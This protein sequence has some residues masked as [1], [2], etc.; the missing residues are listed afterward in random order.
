MRRSGTQTWKKKRKGRDGKSN[1]GK[2]RGNTE[3]WEE[4]REAAEEDKGSEVRRGTDERAQPIKSTRGEG[5]KIG[6]NIRQT[7]HDL[8]VQEEGRKG[9]KL[10]GG[11]GGAF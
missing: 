8:S 3:Q 10:R 2:D 11:A 4:G 5:R 6:G 9:A 1:R 7:Y